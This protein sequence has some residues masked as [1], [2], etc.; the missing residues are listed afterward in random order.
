MPMRIA[1]DCAFWV[2]GPNPAGAAGVSFFL[3]HAPDGSL[4]VLNADASSP[5]PV[6]LALKLQS[7]ENRFAA[8][9]LRS[10]MLQIMEALDLFEAQGAFEM[11]PL[12]FHT[13]SPVSGDTIASKAGK[14]FWK[15]GLAVLEDMYHPKVHRVASMVNDTAVAIMDADTLAQ[16]C[17]LYARCSPEIEVMQPLRIAQWEWSCNGQRAA[18]HLQNQ[19][20]PMSVV[21][22]YDSAS[23]QLL[24]SLQHPGGWMS[25]SWS[26]SQDNLLVSCREVKGNS[27]FTARHE[28]CYLILYIVDAAL[29][30][31]STRSC[32]VTGPGWGGAQSC[33]WTPCGNLLELN[34]GHAFHDVYNRRILACLS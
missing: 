11:N 27:I 7:K 25:I 8:Y 34:I 19:Q 31:R 23:G 24:Q 12:L 10:G 29:Q 16:I 30:T 13:I 9:I 3:T 14:G 6:R 33:Q 5:R 28:E 4:W 21:Q 15:W 2:P 22:I 1:F 20:S 26:S 18:M 32:N 17:C